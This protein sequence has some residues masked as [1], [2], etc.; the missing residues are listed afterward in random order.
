MTADRYPHIDWPRLLGDLQ[1]LLGEPATDGSG[2]VIIAGTPT[3]ATYLGVKR[4][5]LV[6]WIDGAEPKH[7]QGERLI[8]AWT[9]LS[10]KPREFTPITI[11]SLSAAKMR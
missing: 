8:E 4:T 6:G 5:T 9:R 3:L 10:G 2:V 7:S 1:Y 11:V